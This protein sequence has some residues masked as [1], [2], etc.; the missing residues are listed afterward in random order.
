MPLLLAALQGPQADAF[1][2]ESLKADLLFLSDDVLGGRETDAFGGHATARWLEARFQSIGLQPWHG[3]YRAALR[4][5]PLKLDLEQ[6]S[7]TLGDRRFEAGKNF[8]PHPAAP[9]AS[10]TGPLVFAGYGLGPTADLEGTRG[11]KIDGAVV[12][13]LRFAPQPEGDAFFEH[14]ASLPASARLQRKIQILQDQGALAVLLVDPPGLFH[15]TYGREAPAAPYW[16][17]FSALHQALLPTIRNQ[18]DPEALRS[19]NLTAQQ[20]ADLLFVRAQNQTALGVHI[21]V[22]YL[23]PTLA[24]LA[25]AQT[26]VDLDTWVQAVSPDGQVAHGP[27]EL[28]SCGMVATLEVRHQP[29]LTR[30][31]PNILGFLPG[32]EPAEETPFL[33]IGAHFDHVGRNGEGEIWNGADDNASGVLGMLALAAYFGLPEH[34]L[35]RGILFVAFSGEEGGMR[36]SFDLFAQGQLKPEDVHMMLNLDMI[37]RAGDGKLAVL[38]ADSSPVLRGIA[39]ELA[40]DSALQLLFEDDSLFDRSDHL[41]FY[42]LGIPVLFLNTGVHADYHTPGDTWDRVDLHH[43]Q[44]ILAYVAA[45]LVEAC[46]SASPMPFH[47]YQQRRTARFGSPPL[48]DLPWPVPFRQRLDY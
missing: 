20:A 40:A 16:P 36:G 39:D 43:V 42:L 23:S 3:S 37:G 29:E 6:T 2:I 22:G 24:Q 14:G 5:A 7:L 10:A 21:P 30:A 11:S 17:Q 41:P 13:L 19:A 44:R 38:G 26:D 33:V 4:P 27:P 15:G 47:D 31:A 9:A 25:L 35:D 12:L 1:P 8:L 18:A 45:V 48:L 34:R 28:V 32:R 46:A